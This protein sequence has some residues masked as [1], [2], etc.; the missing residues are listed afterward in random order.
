MR[1]FS[2]VGSG[3]GK[4]TNRPTHQ[5]SQGPDK[6]KSSPNSVHGDSNSGHNRSQP[7]GSPQGNN[8]DKYELYSFEKYVPTSFNMDEALKKA[9]SSDSQQS[10]CGGWWQWLLGRK[11]H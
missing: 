10:C 8:V 4:K 3:T 1:F 6:I 5:N 11:Q 9:M 2:I 7:M